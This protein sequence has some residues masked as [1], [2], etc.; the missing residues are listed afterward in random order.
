MTEN[1]DIYIS[2]PD[3]SMSLSKMYIKSNNVINFKSN[4]VINQI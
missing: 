4:Q 1:N 3:N 2:T